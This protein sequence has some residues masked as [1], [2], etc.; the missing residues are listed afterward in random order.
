LAGVGGHTTAGKLVEYS[1]DDRPILIPFAARA[2]ATVEITMN[3][4]R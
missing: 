1:L 3:I 2:T 4:G